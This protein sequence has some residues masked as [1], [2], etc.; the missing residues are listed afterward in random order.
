MGDPSR[1]RARR[2]IALL[3]ERGPALRMPR[4]RPL[5]GG[6]FELRFDLRDEARRI[7]YVFQPGRVAVLL[8]TFRKQRDN[9]R[10]EVDRARQTQRRYKDQL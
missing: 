1:A 5:G 9:E 2:A 8:T 7:T 4:S 10:R 6:L 3:E